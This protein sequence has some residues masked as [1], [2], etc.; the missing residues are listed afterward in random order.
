M[1]KNR[2]ERGPSAS[3]VGGTDLARCPPFAKEV[4]AINWVCNSAVY[5]I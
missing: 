4:D 3:G 2:K 1:S 5:R